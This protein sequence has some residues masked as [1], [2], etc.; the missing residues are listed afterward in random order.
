M[1]GCGG[2]KLD[3]ATFDYLNS[4]GFE[5]YQGYGLTETSPVI[6]IR[7]HFIKNKK[8]VGKPIIGTKIKVVD[9]D[10]NGIG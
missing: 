8:S 2:A 9:K 3:N 4:V 6:S 10:K 1:L 5:I 7:G